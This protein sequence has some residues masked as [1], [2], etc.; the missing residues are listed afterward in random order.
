[1]H[2]WVYAL[3]NSLKVPRSRI[4]D[5]ARCMRAITADTALRLRRYFNTSPEVWVNFESAER[6]AGRQMS[7]SP[8]K[9]AIIHHR[10][11][12]NQLRF[13]G[14]RFGRQSIDY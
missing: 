13:C 3:A 2:L 11:G 10:L 7:A 5:I 1:M 9:A 8:G 4:N 14:R 6:T 12:K